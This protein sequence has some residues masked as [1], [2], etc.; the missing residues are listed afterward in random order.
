[1]TS[2]FI[3][4]LAGGIIFF[5]LLVVRVLLV[6]GVFDPPPGVGR[7]AEKGYEN[8]QGT[9][10]GLRR[11]SA[12]EGR[13]PASLEE[14]IVSGD[15]DELPMQP[16]SAKPMKYGLDPRTGPNEST[17][18]LRFGY[19]G[20]GINTCTYSDTVVQDPKSEPAPPQW[21]HTGDS[22]ELRLNQWGWRC[23]GYH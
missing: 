15:L 1:M 19:I 5:V 23:S 4:L 18:V 3:K 13:Y 11:Y 7:S 17:Y 16:D 8:S 10:E 2:R 9:I 22:R 6:Y 21:K 20:P 12:R 14:L